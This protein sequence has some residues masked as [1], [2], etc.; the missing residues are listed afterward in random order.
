[1]HPETH[2]APAGAFEARHSDMLTETVERFSPPT[3]FWKRYRAELAKSAAVIVV[4][5]ATCLRLSGGEAKSQKP[6]TNSAG[7]AVEAEELT[8]PTSSKDCS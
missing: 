7:K 5:H 4:K 1:M 8:S 6:L 2:V 3:N